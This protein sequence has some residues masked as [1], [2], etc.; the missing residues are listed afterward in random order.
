LRQAALKD[1]KLAASF[2]EKWKD[3]PALV[4]KARA[5]EDVEMRPSGV[6]EEVEAAETDSEV[7]SE[8]EEAWPV[9]A[10]SKRGVRVDLVNP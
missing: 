9:P 3:L 2:L 8:G 6:S 5:G 10:T 1:A 4:R 7:G